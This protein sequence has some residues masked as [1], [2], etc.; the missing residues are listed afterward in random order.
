MKCPY[1]SGPCASI[2]LL[3]WRASEDNKMRSDN[4]YSHP[5]CPQYTAAWVRGYEDQIISALRSE[6]REEGKQ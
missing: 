4:P 2:W 5:R 1:V 3:G 6:K